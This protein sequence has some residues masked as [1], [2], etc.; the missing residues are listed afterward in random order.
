MPPFQLA[1]SQR[2]KVNVALL[3]PAVCAKLLTRYESGVRNGW[4]SCVEFGFGNAAWL[5][6]IGVQPV[7]PPPETK[8]EPA[9]VEVTGSKQAAQQSQYLL[10]YNWS[11][12]LHTRR[13]AILSA[14]RELAPE[15]A[16]LKRL[17]RPLAYP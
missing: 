13:S 5:R 1:A 8:N 3:Q 10:L 2:W 12:S 11:N 7:L 15:S 14:I 6:H 9:A 16:N 4:A 17:V